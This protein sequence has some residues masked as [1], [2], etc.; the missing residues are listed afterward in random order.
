MV[1]LA[2]HNRPRGEKPAEEKNAR[3]RGTNDGKLLYST[4]PA[5]RE[6]HPYEDSSTLY[7]LTMM[8]SSHH[9]IALF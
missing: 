5:A 9:I 6:T 7:E 2:I 1:F 3:V 4:S 8:V